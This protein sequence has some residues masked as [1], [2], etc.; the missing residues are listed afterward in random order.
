V[1]L[2]E[3]EFAFF[4]PIFLAIH[5][6]LPRRAAIQNAALLVGSLFFYA[7]WSLKLLPL[8]LLG[9]AI[10]WLVLR[11]FHRTPLPA[12][13]APEADRTRALRRRRGLLVIGLAQNLGALVWFKYVGFFADSLN[14]ALGA[15]G[16]G[17]SLPVLRL[18]LPLGISFYTMSRIGVLLD[19]YF[20]RLEP[21]RS[22]LVWFT[23]TAFFPPL[24]AGPL[25][26]RIRSSP[27]PVRSR[28]SAT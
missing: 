23:F 10:D 2:S 27:T 7:T 3:V 5:W 28:A 13:D 19:T 26:G 4:F 21:V 18:V 9:T 22:P 24:I 14:Q 17:S 8:F 20:G 12:D 1:S 11:G 16:I 25:G 6:L 15:I